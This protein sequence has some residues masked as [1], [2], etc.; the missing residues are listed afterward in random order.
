MRGKLIAS[1]IRDQS[2]LWLASPR[3]ILRTRRLTFV[4]TNQ[5]HRFASSSVRPC[6]MKNSTICF[7][8]PV[9]ALPAPMKTARWSLAGTPV[10]LRALMIPANMT[11]P[12]PWMSSLKQENL[13]W[14]LSSAIWKFQSVS[15]YQRSRSGHQFEHVQRRE[16]RIRGRVRTKKPYEPG[17]GFLKSSN[18]TTMLDCIS[19]E[20]TVLM[21]IMTRNFTYP[22]QV[23]FKATIN[24]SKNSAS[25]AEETFFLLLPI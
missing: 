3:D 19:I 22:G 8:T 18:W 1:V 14:Y 10:T 7:A 17:K 21:S 23:L 6:L 12:V 25:S 2:L 24:S 9:P 11:A 5:K 16:D 15:T 4:S 20:S 13:C